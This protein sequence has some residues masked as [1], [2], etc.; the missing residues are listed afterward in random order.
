MMEMFFDWLRGRHLKLRTLLRP[1][2][3]RRALDDELRFH[4]EMEADA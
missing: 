3:A 1:D 2:A 4:V